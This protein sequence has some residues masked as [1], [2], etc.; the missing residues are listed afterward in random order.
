MFLDDIPINIANPADLKRLREIFAEQEVYIVAGSDVVHNAS[1]Y[2]KEP[3]ENS[4]HGFNHLIFRRAGDARPGEIYE[5]ITGKVEELELPKSLEDISSTRIRENIDK[6][7]AYS[8]SSI[9][10]SR[11]ISTIRGCICGSRNISPLCG[12]RPFPLKTR[13]SLAGRCWTIWAIRSF[14]GIRRRRRYYP[15]SDTKKTSC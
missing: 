2:K 12:P 9:Q 7:R 4:I 3:E 10:W 15:G 5:C 13:V 14:T 1:S 6:H 8:S 11:S